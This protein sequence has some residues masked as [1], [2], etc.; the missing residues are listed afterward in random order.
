M[1]QPEQKRN[2]VHRVGS[3]PSV[4][5]EAFNFGVEDIGLLNKTFFFE[6]VI[7]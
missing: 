7:K 3:G 1:T 6:K 5:R 4:D 2:P